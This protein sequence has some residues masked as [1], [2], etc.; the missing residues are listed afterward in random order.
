LALVVRYAIFVLSAASV[1][2][3]GGDEPVQLQTAAQR[4]AIQVSVATVAGRDEPVTI[5]AIGSF[6]AA[7]SSEVA[8]ESPGV[9]VAT[10]VDVGAFVRA[11]AVLVRLQATDARLVVEEA[12]AAVARAEANAKL[13]DAQRQL[14]ETT[15]KRYESL[16]A[17]GDVSRT[18]ADQARTEAETALQTG[19]TARASLAEARAK[20]ARAEHDMS[21][22]AVT[23]PFSGHVNERHVSLG[24]YVQPSTPVVTLL[25]I[26]PLR[27]RLEI[28]AAQAG[29]VKVGQKVSATVDAYPGRTFTG[30]L[31]AVTPALDPESRT[32]V[33]E[34][35]VAN[36][37]A[38]LKPGMFGVATIAQSEVARTLLVPRSAVMEDVNTNSY[39][40]FV[41]DDQ[42]RARVR[43]LQL[44]ARQLGDPVRITSGVKEGERV[45]TSNLGD[46][47]DGAAV[48][49]VL[50]R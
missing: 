32:L 40:L 45:A 8:P 47:Y 49:I 31:A 18:V 38:L 19:N 41:I 15:S 1:P 26:D 48:E 21:H 28:P 46:L 10:P 23:A 7:E 16:V 39:R 17:T 25:K 36:P 33:V 34:A 44:A 22:V 11:G 42:N 27:L 35:H 2:A 9:V 5:E 4:T 20:L 12:K 37:D 3:C 13:A 43:V 6:D 24:E 14:A 50:A 30:E 29:R